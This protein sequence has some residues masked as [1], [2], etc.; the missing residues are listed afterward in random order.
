M[1]TG[2]FEAPDPFAVDAAGDLVVRFVGE[3]GRNAQFPLTRLPLPGWVEPLGRAFATRIG[4]TGSLRTRVSAYGVWVVL[5]QFV[6]FLAALPSPP[7]D[8]SRL[9]V[10][11]LTAFRADITRR[12]T[13]EASAIAHFGRLASV[14]LLPP[15]RELLD[16]DVLDVLL[17]RR[18]LA[19]KHPGKDGYSDGEL[20]R[21]VTRLRSDAAAIRDR[22]E[23]GR[24][25]AWQHR[26]A[27]HEIAPRERELARQLAEIADTGVVPAI[28][29]RLKTRGRLAER[30]FMVPADV[31]PLS[32][33]FV[34]VS[35]RNIETIKELPAAHTVVADKAV[36]VTVTKRRRGPGRWFETVSWEIGPAGQELHHPGGLFLLVHRLSA[37]SREFSGAD[38]IWTVWRNGLRA[39]VTD[40]GEHYC[41]FGAE[42]RWPYQTSW[43]ATQQGLWADPVDGQP[44]RRL[45]LDCVRLRKS[46]EVR[47]TK[48]MGGHLPSAARSNTYPV[49]F[50]SYLRG[51]ATARGWAHDVVASALV[52]AENAAWQAHQHALKRSGGHLRVIGGD[53]SARRLAQ[54]GLST[55]RAEAIAAGEQ[56]SAW[57]ACIDPDQHP[58][59]GKPCSTPSLLDCFHCGNC[60]V[61]RTHLPGLL[62]L[63]TALSQ[64]RQ[65][66]SEQRWWQ[67]Y[68][69]TWVAIRRDII[70]GRHFSKAEIAHARTQQPLD[71]LLDLVENPWEITP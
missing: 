46:V 45:R 60:L 35:A 6:D 24:R 44:P 22:I 23:G 68:G 14:L 3:D 51:D 54:D 43:A 70:D 13:S 2:R 71:A 8:P 36:E 39:D 34:V 59:T 50:S 29:G 7:P 15:A 66:M 37:P 47:R 38:S 56:N 12:F 11:H 30:L 63:L 1:P 27:A 31:I 41:P 17:A 58:D 67:R 40:T 57:T 26:H 48:Q 64:R 9:R 10:G 28:A 53:P 21:L 25:L 49:L 52:D 33:L 19:R 65:Q 55:D 32:A 4:P 62:A 61:T 18:P 5:G 42:L 69:P 20:R 16:R